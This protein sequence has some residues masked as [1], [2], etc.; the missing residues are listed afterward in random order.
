MPA[1]A[2]RVTPR[3]WPRGS[4]FSARRHVS[5]GHVRARAEGARTARPGQGIRSGGKRAASRAPRSRPRGPWLR[6][7]RPGTFEPAR[8]DGARQATRTRQ[9]RLNLSPDPQGQG[10]FRPGRPRPEART[11][12]AGAL[13]GAVAGV[14]G[15]AGGGVLRG[16]C[17]AFSATAFPSRLRRRA[18]SNRATSTAR[19]SASSSAWNQARASRSGAASR[20]STRPSSRPTAPKKPGLLLGSGLGRHFITSLPGETLAEMSV[21]STTL[22]WT[23]TCLS[24]QDGFVQKSV[25]INSPSRDPSALS[26]QSS[27]GPSSVSCLESF[28]FALSVAIP[29]EA[30]YLG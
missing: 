16:S 24:G 5:A 26:R 23:K 1:W 2:R 9:Q 20:S 30:T 17:S 12:P 19:S 21:S 7:C 29:G 15:G 25:V 11:G 10:S 18:P 22:T 4:R 6:R 13:S 14:A 27:M 8:V 28:E 3:A